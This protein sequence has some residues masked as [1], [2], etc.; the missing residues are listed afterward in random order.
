[1]QAIDLLIIPQSISFQFGHLVQKSRSNRILLSIAT[2]FIL[3]QSV[4][5]I[6][7]Q[8]AI[9]N[10]SEERS[11][12]DFT[13]DLILL[14]YDCKTDVD[15]LHSV[16]AIATLLRVPS[17]SNIKYHA[18]AG[19]YGTQKGNYVPPYSLFKLA[20]N[21]NWSDAHN[22]FDKALNDT[23]SKV[24]QVINEGGK[25][26]IAE[27]GQSDFSS[28]LI[29]RIQKNEKAIDTRHSIIVVQH[30]EWNESVTSPSRL[31]FVKSNSNYY[32]I[33]DGNA[34]DNGTPGFKTPDK[35]N[36]ENRLKNPE[37]LDIWDLAIELANFYNGK[38][39]RYLNTAIK[40]GGLDFSDFSEVH[41]I[42]NM[43]PMIDCDDFFD[44]I[45]SQF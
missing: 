4:D 26:W 36:W 18:V 24:V 28:A 15:D 10:R 33:P 23:Y 7:Q 16:A 20:F 41:W 1:M 19:A 2:V 14:N 21:N 35:I 32:K 12:F 30:S 3:F 40:E 31:T 43:A 22:N 45:N 38:D 39:G 42:L 34:T 13:K 37:C 29:A 27:A 5:M 11:P 25:V 9:K 8:D 17:F 6:G 44:F